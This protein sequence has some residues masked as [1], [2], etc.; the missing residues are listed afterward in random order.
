MGEAVA[1]GDLADPAKGGPGPRALD[2]PPRPGA[3]H[4]PVEGGRG[5]RGAD[6]REGRAGGPRVLLPGGGRLRHARHGAGAVGVPAGGRPAARGR[7]GHRRH[8][9]GGHLRRPGAEGSRDAELGE[10]PRR[11]GRP[12]LRARPRE[13]R[14]HGRAERERWYAIQRAAP[15][16]AWGV[17]QR[18]DIRRR[19]DPKHDAGH[20]DRVLLQLRE[21]RGRRGHGG[22][23]DGQAAGFWLR[24]L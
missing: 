17:R 16:P 14:G 7:R 9:R 3:E 10:R 4:G 20:V 2:R 11:H 6:R 8:H 13:L 5:V 18:E 21:H 22:Q 1:A 15:V 24:R 19:P 12:L 23:G